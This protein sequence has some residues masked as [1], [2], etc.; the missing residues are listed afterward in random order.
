MTKPPSRL[1]NRGGGFVMRVLSW[2]YLSCDKFYSENH[3]TYDK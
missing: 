1:K 2:M 3:L